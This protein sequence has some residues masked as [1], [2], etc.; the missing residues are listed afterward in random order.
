VG[1][2]ASPATPNMPRVHNTTSKDRLIITH[3]HEKENKM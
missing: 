3:L 2:A 1:W